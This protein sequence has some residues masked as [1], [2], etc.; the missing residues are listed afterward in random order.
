V[1][2]RAEGTAPGSA[3]SSRKSCTG[4]PAAMSVPRSWAGGTGTGAPLSRGLRT[5]AAVPPAVPVPPWAGRA[6][7]SCGGVLVLALPVM[8]D[9]FRRYRAVLA[10][11]QPRA[12]EVGDEHHDHGRHGRT[13]RPGHARSAPVPGSPDHQV[14]HPRHRSRRRP[15][16]MRRRAAMRRRTARRR[17]TRTGRKRLPLKRTREER[18]LL[19]PGPSRQRTL[20][21]EEE[22]CRP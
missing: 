2:R 7:P 9:S 15:L 17:A 8:N 20:A 6:Q 19:S 21:A 13:N 14:R 5:G 12:I 3:P 22:T 10:R 18:D 4:H 16:P 1:C 11:K